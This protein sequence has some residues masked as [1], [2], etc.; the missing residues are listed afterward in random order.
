MAAAARG[1]SAAAPS[2]SGAGQQAE[3]GQQGQR[4]REDRW[5]ERRRHQQR[6]HRAASTERPAAERPSWRPPSPR[7]ATSGTVFVPVAELQAQPSCAGVWAMLEGIPPHQLA[8][9][10]V[11][12]AL[13]H[14]VK[15]GKTA[16]QQLAA[17]DRAAA[18]QLLALALGRLGALPARQLVALIRF[19]T[20]FKAQAPLA[21]AGLRDWQAAVGR[22]GVI[23]ELNAQGV[24]NALLSLGTLADASAALAAAVDR[25]LAAKLLQRAADVVGDGSN[26]PRPVANALYGTAL[27]GLQPSAE[28]ANALF[29]GVGEHVDGMAGENLTQ[30]SWLAGRRGVGSKL[31]ILPL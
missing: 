10:S 18:Q 20:A 3:G 11:G 27:L 15:L 21:P 13:D 29:R 31:V 12:A 8:P 1:L 6:Q 23:R 5:A 28:E 14:A 2:G 26:D 9:P 7:A 25:Q 30:A 17:A 22:P 24:S 16:G 19:A 4:P